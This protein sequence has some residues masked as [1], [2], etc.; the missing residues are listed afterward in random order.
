MTYV[1][2]S[3]ARTTWSSIPTAT[4]SFYS[5]SGTRIYRPSRDSL[6][7]K[8]FSCTVR[9][10]LSVER[11]RPIQASCLCTWRDS[12]TTGHCSWI[13]EAGWRTREIFQ[14]TT[15]CGLITTLRVPRGGRHK[16]S[17]CR[18]HGTG[19]YTGSWNRRLS[20]GGTRVQS[21][22]STRTKNLKCPSSLF[23]FMVPNPITEQT[24]LPR[25]I[26]ELSRTSSR[27]RATIALSIPTTK[28]LSLM[29]C[30]AMGGRRRP[31]Y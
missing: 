17:F 16:I 23:T 8:H 27:E 2:V 7:P 3:K 30:A 10:F 21:V 11:N 15:S 5:P 31:G 14:N 26:G 25:V 1:R 22:S 19:K 13:L 20:M 6:R 9:T 18:R 28:S 29:V 12:P 24:R 4:F